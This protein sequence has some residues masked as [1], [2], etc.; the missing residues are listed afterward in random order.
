MRIPVAIALGVLVVAASPALAQVPTMPRVTPGQTVWVTRQD[1]TIVT[2]K[3]KT[4]AETGLA[5]SH[6]NNETSVPLGEIRQIE[7]TDSLTNGIIIGA[8]PT[9]LL[10]GFGAGLGASYGSL[11]SGERDDGGANRAAVVGLIVG[12]GVG[13]L[14]GG[15]IDRAIKGRR[16]IYRASTTGAALTIAPAPAIRGAGLRVSFRW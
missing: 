8:I 5:V 4:V 1:D 12:A 14:I 15:A 6:G 10:F 13:A 3:V 7:T 9:S 11:A 2:G 16:V